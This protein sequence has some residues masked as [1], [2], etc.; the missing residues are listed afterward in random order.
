MSKKI[1]L[2]AKQQEAFAAIKKFYKEN[3]KFPN[4]NQLAAALGKPVSISNAPAAVQ[5]YGA[6]FLKGAFTDGV[7]LTD[8]VFAGHSG[9]SIAALNVGEL[10][11]N[12]RKVERGGNQ[13]GNRARPVVS[14][15]NNAALASALLELLKSSPK[16]NEI[17]A[18]L[19][20]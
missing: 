15:R 14:P 2:T 17:A 16:F 19:N 6:L 7:V 9:G 12:V 10:K 3:G 13:Y 11:F 5:M 4:G 18:A 8:S 1:C 20:G